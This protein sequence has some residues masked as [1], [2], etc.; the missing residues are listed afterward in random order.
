MITL[1]RTT[2]GQAGRMSHAPIQS[3]P[4]NLPCW[5][6]NGAI[7]HLALLNLTLYLNKA[8]LVATWVAMGVILKRYGSTFRQL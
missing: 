5:Q 8:W 6:A 2:I 4:F 7:R 3:A 1:G